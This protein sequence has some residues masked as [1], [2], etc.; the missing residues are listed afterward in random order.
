[1]LQFKYNSMSE[2]PEELLNQLREKEGIPIP[3]SETA[4]ENPGGQNPPETPSGGEGGEGTQ[5]QNPAPETPSQEPQ[6]P[7]PAAELP[8]FD[9]SPFAQKAGKEI[10]T[11]EDLLKWMDEVSNKKPETVKLDDELQSLADWRAKGGTIDDWYRI[12]HTD[13]QAEAQK[14]PREVLFQYRKA[15]NQ[16]GLTDD[17][18]RFQIED[19]H[20][21]PEEG[22]ENDP[23]TKRATIKLKT[24]LGSAVNWFNERKIK[25]SLPAPERERLSATEIFNKRVQE[26]SQKAMQLK[27][28]QFGDYKHVIDDAFKQATINNPQEFLGKYVQ[29]DDKGNLIGMDY[30]TI[31]R[32]RFI[33][34]N[35]NAILGSYAKHEATKTI[36]ALKKEI[37]NPQAKPQHQNAPAGKT[38]KTDAELIREKFFGIQP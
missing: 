2:I 10:K 30:E 22:M 12:H 31:T 36:E 17:E 25:E 7:A 38:T 33:L 26:T 24:E 8:Q 1:M 19:E 13:W 27:E 18:I 37:S 4:P 11:Q 9:Y 5:P 15:N 14:D 28:L 3:G 16:Y 21:R 29:L 34:Q 6:N 35:V 23:E 20:P 32:D